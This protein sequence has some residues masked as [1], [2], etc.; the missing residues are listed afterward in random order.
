MWLLVPA[1]QGQAVQHRLAARSS[2]PG[3]A[4]SPVAVAVPEEVMAGH[5]LKRV[6]PEKPAAASAANGS[7]VIAATVTAEGYIRRATVV[8][9]PEPLRAST[10]FAVRQWMYTPYLVNGVP[11]EVETTI[12]MNFANGD[13]MAGQPVKPGDAHLSS[14]AEPE[15]EAVASATQRPATASGVAKLAP[16]PTSGTAIAPIVSSV[17]RKGSRG[18]AAQSPPAGAAA[19]TRLA[20]ASPARPF[21]TARPGPGF[22]AYAAPPL[23]SPVY[24][25]V[26]WRLVKRVAPVYPAAAESEGIEGVVQVEAIIRKDGSLRSLRAISGPAELRQAAVDAASQWEYALIGGGKATAE[27]S[28]TAT[29][30]FVL[31]GPAKVPAE[32]MAGRIEQSVTPPYPPDAEAAGVSGSVVLHVLISRDGR[33]EQAEAISGPPM[34]RQAALDA[35]KQWTWKPYLRAGVHVEVETN[36]VIA[37]SRPGAGVQ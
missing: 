7:V 36:V 12:T 6:E 13:V 10:L 18:G 14:S 30:E 19:A 15:P 32:V 29:V 35:V 34:L 20:D 4:A 23:A 9:G 1:L 33:A 28:T 25:P 5:L 37:F 16:A 22:S 26:P 2:G 8:S 27:G 21:A 24:S 31:R 17:D 3:A 11:A